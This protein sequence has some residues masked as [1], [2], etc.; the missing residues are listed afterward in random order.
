MISDGLISNQLR[1]TLGIYHLRTIGLIFL[2]LGPTQQVVKC[3]CVDHVNG[4]VVEVPLW[5]GMMLHFRIPYPHRLWSYV[6]F[7]Y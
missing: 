4:L 2:A 5:R 3:V 6:V 7:S 1:T